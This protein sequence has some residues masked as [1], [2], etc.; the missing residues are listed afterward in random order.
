M[1]QALSHCKMLEVQCEEYQKAKER[2]CTNLASIT[3]THPPCIWM[4]FLGHFIVEVVHAKEPRTYP[5]RFYVFEDATSP[6]IL[7]SY[8]TLRRL[9]IVSFQVPN[10]AATHKIDHVALPNPPSSQRKTAKHVTFQDPLSKT[11]LSHTSS[12][13]STSHCSK[14]KT[15]S[16]KGEEMPLTSSHSR[17]IG[18]HQEAKVGK[19]NHYKTLNPSQVL[20]F[21]SCKTIR[22]PTLANTP[23]PT[24]PKPFL[25]HP[26]VQSLPVTSPRDVAQ[27]WDIMVLKRA[28]PDSSDTIGNMPGTYS[29]RTDPAFPPVQ[30]ARCK[31]PIEYRDQIE[32]ALDEMVLKGVIAPVLK[33]TA[34]VSSLTY[35]CKP[36]GS[37]CICLNPK[38]LNKVLVQEHYKTPTLAEITHCLSGGTCFSKLDAKDGFWSIHLDEETSYLTRFNT[39]HGRYRFLHM[40][41]G[42]KM[43]QDVF[44]I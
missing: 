8:A 10:L 16:L 15:A 4:P 33:P 42:L 13:T 6:H 12:N 7:L 22:H 1:Y 18:K 29:I 28:F 20:N 36:D 38:D 27:I 32:K 24:I 41:F 35:P 17:T 34:W 3:G 9:G 5:V 26:K 43:S 11:E 19:I 39:H 14:R 21:P 2:G 37:L 31:V 30:H 23:L 40:P 44:Q 25:C